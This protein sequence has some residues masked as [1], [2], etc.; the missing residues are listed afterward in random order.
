MATLKSNRAVGD[1]EG[2]VGG[3]VYVHRADGTV[4]VRR[5]GR[6]RAGWNAGQR[7]SQ[8][9][10]REAQ[11]YVKRIKLNPGEYAFY[12]AEERVQHKR[13]CDLAIRDYLNSPVIQDVDASSFHGEVGDAIRVQASDDFRVVAVDVNIRRIDDSALVESGGATVDSDSGCWIYS[14]QS[15]YA[16]GGTVSIDI[17]A[18]DRPG[19]VAQKVVHHALVD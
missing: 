3:L 1:L 5:L 11:A 12:K 2:T 16:H 19:N 15:D 17:T 6:R 8:S 14:T 7:A 13:A 10:F 4:I 9:R 18:V